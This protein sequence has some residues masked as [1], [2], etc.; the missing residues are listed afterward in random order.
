[1]SAPHS[2]LRD[3]GLRTSVFDTRTAI[4]LHLR[5]RPHTNNGGIAAKESGTFICLSRLKPQWTAAYPHYFATAD[6]LRPPFHIGIDS[7][8]I[9]CNLLE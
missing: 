2:T 4:A 7:A 5:A 8:F 3:M 1:M 9:V 6:V